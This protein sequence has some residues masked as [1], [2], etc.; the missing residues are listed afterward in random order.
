M[1]GLGLA[2]VVHEDQRSKISLALKEI[3]LN[4]K[5]LPTTLQAD[6]SSGGLA[7]LKTGLGN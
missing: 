1:A 7:H 6:E 5:V 2:L 4:S 3:I